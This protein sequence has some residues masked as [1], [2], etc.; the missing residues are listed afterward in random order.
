MYDV[1]YQRLAVLKKKKKKKRTSFFWI[2]HYISFSRDLTDIFLRGLIW[3]LS[4]CLSERTLCCCLLEG[5]FLR[6]QCNILEDRQTDRHLKM[7]KLDECTSGGSRDYSTKFFLG[8]SR[9]RVDLLWHESKTTDKREQ[10]DWRA[11][12]NL[13]GYCN[14]LTK[15]LYEWTTEAVDRRS[16]PSKFFLAL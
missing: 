13:D 14:F 11:E 3:A 7:V 5:T 1:L 9:I 6:Q 16:Y 10:Y 12:K 2:A 15:L 4:V 8:S